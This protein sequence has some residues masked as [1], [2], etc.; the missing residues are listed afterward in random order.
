MQEKPSA[1]VG[2]DDHRQALVPGS[3]GIGAAGQ[4]DVVGVLDQARPH[5]LAVDDPLVTVALGAGAQRRRG[6]CRRPAR[7]SRSRSAARPTRSAAGRIAF[8]ASVP[9]R[10]IVGPTVLIVRNGTGAPAIAASSVKI[11]CS[12]IDAPRPPYCSG[13][14]SVSQPSRPSGARPRGRPCRRR[15]HRRWPVRPAARASS[16]PRSTRAARWRRRSCSGV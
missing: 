6:R 12:S 10:M 13:Q 3:V 8:C 14:L 2:H 11:S 1:V 4:P 16:A 15:S 5:L 7:S 9:K